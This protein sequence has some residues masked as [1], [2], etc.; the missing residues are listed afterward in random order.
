M[1]SNELENVQIKCA[2]WQNTAQQ[3][4]AALKAIIAMNQQHAHD[5]FGDANKAESW[6]CI[7]VARKA[8]AAMP[9]VES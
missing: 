1:K 9:N 6:A 3:L 2:E 7:K 5:Q 4:E 8:L